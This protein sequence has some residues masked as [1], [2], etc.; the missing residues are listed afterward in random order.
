MNKFIFKILKIGILFLTIAYLISLDLESRFRETPSLRRIKVS[1][2]QKAKRLQAILDDPDISRIEDESLL[3]GGILDELLRIDEKYEEKYK[4]K[5]A[6]GILKIYQQVR[7]GDKPF[8]SF[9]GIFQG[10]QG[11]INAVIMVRDAI[12]REFG[13]DDTLAE[14]IPPKKGWKKWLEDEEQKLNT[15]AQI[16]VVNDLIRG[17]LKEKLYPNKKSEPHLHEWE[18]LYRINWNGKE[19]DR[20]IKEAVPH[21][22]V[23]HMGL[24]LDESFIG[25]IENWEKWAKEYKLDAMLRTRFN[26]SGRK[27]LEFVY[28]EKFYPAEGHVWHDWDFTIFKWDTEEGDR[29]AKDWIRHKLFD[30][31]HGE[32]WSIEGLAKRVKSWDKWAK[33]D[34]KLW[35]M[36][37]RKFGSILPALKFA[38]EEEFA[39]GKIEISDFNFKY[40]RGIAELE[41]PLT[42][43]RRDSSGMVRKGF[44]KVSYIFS[45]EYEG[46]YLAPISEDMAGLYKKRDGI[47][48]LVAEFPLKD[49]E[50]NTLSIPRAERLLRE[51]SREYAQY[52][53]EMEKLSVPEDKARIIL[54]D[55]FG[56][57]VNKLTRREMVRLIVYLNTR[58]EDGLANFLTQAGPYGITILGNVSE[59]L[60]AE[61]LVASL[62][63]SDRDKVFNQYLEIHNRIKTIAKSFGLEARGIKSGK[64]NPADIPL[65]GKIAPILFEEAIGASLIKANNQLMN[66]LQENIGNRKIVRKVILAQEKLLFLVKMLEGIGTKDLGAPILYGDGAE[67]YRFTFQGESVRLLLRPKESADGE[68]GIRFTISPHQSDEIGFRIDRTR[69]RFIPGLRQKVLVVDIDLSKFI[70]KELFEYHFELG[71]EHELKLAEEEIFSWLVRMVW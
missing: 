9:R 2:S 17:A 1:L 49:W 10:K 47:Y 30:P 11:F 39:E 26:G 44:G 58:G 51:P 68:A 55:R 35:M 29:I 32:G 34:M 41:F 36:M 69:S 31:I 65:L 20:I 40:G 59:P 50:G 53:A 45:K 24:R 28:P 46:Y 19:G 60:T 52:L 62:E 42:E 8:K 43:L 6:S 13:I 15:P 37:V 66:L 27:M 67:E 21:I 33:K 61:V 70:E 54:R 38:L 14:R 48:E 23:D 71:E 5:A 12:E 57:D 64:I 4:E 25:R 3:R 7:K 63:G 18:I 16:F 22:L 56:I